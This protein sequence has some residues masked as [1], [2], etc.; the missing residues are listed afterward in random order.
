MRQKDLDFLEACKT[1]DCHVVRQFILSGCDPILI[2]NEHGQN[3]LH[4]A[5]L[6]GNMDIVELLVKVY[7]CD[8]ETTDHCGRTSLHLACMGGSIMVTDYL[9]NNAVVD[10]NIKDN[11]DNTI[12]HYACLSG[13]VPT[14]RLVIHMLI[15]ER[16]FKLNIYKDKP[17]PYTLFLHIAALFS[18]TC[19]TL[20]NKNGETALHTACRAGHLPVL[21]CFVEEFYLNQ[22]VSEVLISVSKLACQCGRHDIFNYLVNSGW[23]PRHISLPELSSD[24]G[25]S[26]S[27]PSPQE[28]RENTQKCVPLPSYRGVSFRASVLKPSLKF[29]CQN[30]DE[31]LVRHLIED[32]KCNPLVPD[33]DTGD[34]PLHSAAISGN[35]SLIS[36][37][38]DCHCDPMKCNDEGNTPLHE[39][40][41]WGY[42][43]IVE[44]L[45]DAEPSAINASNESM[46]SPLHL[47]CSRNKSHIGKFL[48]SIDSCDIMALNDSKETPLHVASC[49]SDYELI[50]C[51]LKR[52]KDALECT[53]IYK[54]TP[55]FNACRV[56]DVDVVKLFVEAGCDPLHVNNR[57]HEL[58]IHIACRTENVELFQCLKNC[59][60]TESWQLTNLFGQSPLHL[61][62]EQG[63]LLL[64]KEILEHGSYDLDLQDINGMTP[65]HIACKKSNTEIAKVIMAQPIIDFNIGD[66]DGNTPLHLACVNE[67]TD[68]VTL[69]MQYE[70]DVTVENKKGD[71]PVHIASE[72]GRFEV[73]NKVLGTKK[74]GLKFG[75]N[76]VGVT[77]LHIASSNGYFEMVKCLLNGEYCDPNATSK[78]ENCTPLHFACFEGHKDIAVFLA[79]CAPQTLKVYDVHGRCPVVLAFQKKN[80]DVIKSLVPQYFDPNSEISEGNISLFFYSCE[81]GDTDLLKHLVSVAKCN[82]TLT[83]S[84]WGTAIHLI[85]M[86]INQQ[87]DIDSK[88]LYVM[89]VCST[90][91]DCVNDRADT[92]LLL[93]CKM[94]KNNVV[95]MLLEHNANPCCKDSTGDSPLHVA[96]KSQM[97]DMVKTLLHYKADVSCK[98]SAGNTPLHI[99]CGYHLHD[100]ID[101]L[102]QYEADTASQNSH[103]DTPLHI[104]SRS[105]VGECVR[106]LLDH[107]ADMS[108]KNSEGKT[109]IQV[110]TSYDVTMMLIDYG[111]N[112]Q[113]VYT[114]YGEVLEKCKQEQPLHDMVKIFIVGNALAGKTTLVE[115]LKR[116][117]IHVTLVDSVTER[118]AGIVSTQFKSEKLGYV[119]FHD[120]AGQQ[121]F[122]SSHSQFLVSN[123]SSDAIVLLLVN[124]LDENSEL[125][126]NISY[127]MS[128]I[129]HHCSTADC[130]PQ[131]VV[132]C[133]HLDKLDDTKAQ[134]ELTLK[135]AI[136]KYQCL[137]LVFLDCRD[138]ASEGMCQLKDLL[139]GI[140]DKVRSNIELDCQCHVLFAFMHSRFEDTV[141]LGEVQ[142]AIRKKRE[143]VSYIASNLQP[144][145]PWRENVFY[146]TARSYSHRGNIHIYTRDPGDLL[147]HAASALLN[148]LKTLDQKGHILLLNNENQE[149]RYWIVLKQDVFYE[150]VHGTLFAPKNFEENGPIR[151]N[152][153]VVPLSVLVQ[154]F[155]EHTT[156]LKL[157]TKYLIYKEFCHRID[158]PETLKL[159]S[160]ET[161]ALMESDD[162]LYFFPCFIKSEKK[163]TAWKRRSGQLYCS[164]WCLQ[165]RDDHFF[166]TNFLHVLLLRLT[167]KYAVSCK[168]IPSTS[169]FTRRCDIWKNG[170]H[171]FT[172]EGIEVLV[173]LTHNFTFLLVVI[174]SLDTKLK[175]KMECVKLRASVIR[176][177][178]DVVKTTC[179][180]LKPKESLILPDLQNYPDCDLMSAEKISIWEVAETIKKGD[181][182]SFS[183]NNELFDLENVLFFEPYSG[184]GERLLSLLYKNNEEEIPSNNVLKLSQCFSNRKD[185]LEYMLNASPV[186]S[187]DIQAHPVCQKNPELIPHYVIEHWKLS[188]RKGSYSDLKEAFDKYSIFSSRNPLTLCN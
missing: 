124:A 146:I 3:A 85:V 122:Y 131:I 119:T 18:S 176:T 44:K 96:C 141:E 153:G 182:F 38:L 77:P 105:G 149:E 114:H 7:G 1:K 99:A 147:P 46:E 104:A 68:I 81:H 135:Q 143:N 92:P 45:I 183:T 98:N 187:G 10:H 42:L 170:I 110:T 39:A 126:K 16:V 184:I 29:A 75:F 113:D 185:K 188:T 152:I 162:E 4:V 172:T 28:W 136:Q 177:I 22:F 111:A 67:N 160:S 151:T 53:D 163:D 78:Q 83:S 76:N 56:G 58:P 15:S 32:Y 167:F 11:S 102:L 173:E 64:V 150:T 52:S 62:C 61:V 138:P 57:T 93:A 145:V 159:I 186:D 82:P 181:S 13:D 157:I 47:A 140:C 97:V 63:N 139:G 90:Q 33:S 88:F 12:L 109:P 73:L 59:M 120:F 80:Y 23:S 171:W 37:L 14:V 130:L 17:T 94:A 91:I 66:G 5:S 106:L 87:E 155:C 89:D 121:E 54:D 129:K 20:Q 55:L 51:I 133:S 74:H 156:D 72:H 48:V 132:I 154:V 60:N 101:M 144:F 6:H 70:P 8:P 26:P 164:G 19:I 95:T 112:P 125:M 137:G 179:P 84:Q 169:L 24:T 127:W 21:R 9:I 118:T 128:F 31:R 34:T 71:T 100:I 2:Q 30:G 49:S 36:F 35:L 165:C 116:K 175:V 41:K 65:L 25:S 158:D 178:F 123:L 107:K 148:L 69:I 134:K 50:E 168:D 166:P 161:N 43:E 115:A 117:N 108:C 27:S 174:R 79:Q 142:R 103:G 86:L 180:G 40:C